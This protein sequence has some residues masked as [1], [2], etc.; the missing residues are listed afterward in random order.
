[1][2]VRIYFDDAS[3]ITVE[4]SGAPV[5]T[6]EM[7]VVAATQLLLHFHGRLGLVAALLRGDWGM[8]F[9]CGV[10]SEAVPAS[11]LIASTP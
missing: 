10:V 11:A 3:G 9:P 4:A 5:V 7:D 6:D 1:A 8:V 2:P